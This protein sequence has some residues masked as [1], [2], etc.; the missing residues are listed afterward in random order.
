MVLDWQLQLDLETS[1]LGVV[2]LR[3]LVVWIRWQKFAVLA[4]FEAITRHVVREAELFFAIDI[5]EIL[6]LSNFQNEFT[7]DHFRLNVA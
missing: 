6:S 5:N 7:S 2:V 4:T 3:S 1:I